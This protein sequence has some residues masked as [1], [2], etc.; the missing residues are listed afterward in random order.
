MRL[1]SP[2]QPRLAN[3]EAT[4]VERLVLALADDII[5][6]KLQG[7]DRLPAHR[8]LAWQLAIGLGTVTKAYAILERRGLVRS[9]KG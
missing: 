4:T 5:E 7:G 8:T 6:G 1:Q 2:W 3:V 9:V